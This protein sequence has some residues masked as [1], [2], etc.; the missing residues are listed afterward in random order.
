M[1]VCLQHGEIWDKQSGSGKPVDLGSHLP[2]AVWACQVILSATNFRTSLGPPESSWGSWGCSNADS[3][4]DDVATL[5][6]SLALYHERYRWLMDEY[7]LSHMVISSV[8]THPHINPLLIYYLQILTASSTD[9]PVIKDGWK[10]Q[11]SLVN[12]VCELKHHHFH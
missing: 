12:S 9:P 3:C 6:K 1:L 2:F 5:V 8:L 7:S 4:K 11:H 10:I